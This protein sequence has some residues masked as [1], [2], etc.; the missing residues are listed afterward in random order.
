[1][2]DN[3]IKEKI[4]H[5]F[6][7]KWNDF[8]EWFIE[9]E[10]P[11]SKLNKNVFFHDLLKFIGLIIVFAIVNA[12]VDKLNQIVI[13]FIKLGSLAGLVFLIFI[14]KKAW[15]LI[16]NLKYAF[17]GLNNG[18][19]AIMAILIVLLLVCAFFNQGKVI[20]TITTTYEE[21]NFSKINPINLGNFTFGNF[22]L[23]NLLSAGSSVKCKAD[24]DEDI[25]KAKIKNTGL[26]V[27]TIES[28]SFKELDDALEYINSWNA[29]NGDSTI[30]YIREHP[31]TQVDSI[32]LI[33][34]RF[35]FRECIFGECLD[36]SQL[37][38]SVCEG[39]KAIHPTGGLF[40]DLFSG[41]FG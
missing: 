19:K 35:D 8:C 31:Q 1:M 23:S 5:F 21:I 38:F 11:H 32:G 26:S 28:K 27:K 33:V 17:R 29:D 14:I 41:L 20:D 13:I 4:K 25:R 12:N 3:Q 16:I 10:H 9:K 18:T 36:Y 22:S 37:K 30:K 24:F 39:D 7:R 15:N 40:S 34:V 2:K 6:I